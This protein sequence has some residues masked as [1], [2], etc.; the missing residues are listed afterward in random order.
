MVLIYHVYFH[1]LRC[2]MDNGYRT[3]YMYLLNNRIV[4]LTCNSF[5]NILCKVNLQ[6]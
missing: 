4:G 1:I 5:Y 6:L 3:S 2:L